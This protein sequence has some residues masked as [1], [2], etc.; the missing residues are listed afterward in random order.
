MKAAVFRQSKGLV[1]EEIPI[2]DIDADQVLVKVANTG[3]CGSDHTILETAG[4]PDGIVLGHEVSGTVVGMGANVEGVSEGSRVIIRPTYCGKC[5][6]CRMGRPQL[7]SDNRRS[8][9]IGDLPGGFAEYIKVF[10]QMLIPIPENV[11]SRNAALAEAFAV[12][13]HAIKLTGKGDGSALVVG[14]GSI[15]LTLVK[16]L[17]LH[18]FGPVAVSE[19]VRNKRDLALEFGADV[20]VDPLSENLGQR[21]FEINAGSGF[22]TIFECS[23]RLEMLPASMDLVSPG[24]TVCQL[25]VLYDNVQINPATLMFKEVALMASYGNT[26]EDN[27]QC[28]ELMSQ[29]KLDARPLISDLATLDELPRIYRERIHP[30]KA[31]KVML[32]IGEEF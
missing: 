28:L 3:F 23:G 15:G 29:G 16:T 31:I 14:G 1:I 25:S 32:R 7:C 26:H 12:G 27:I 5:P 17:K 24:G 4:T 30:G 13:L 11:D 2:P 21:A 10:P 18:G 6:G 22:E 9:G 19:P 20:V 8:I